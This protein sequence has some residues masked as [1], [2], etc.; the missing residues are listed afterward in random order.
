MPGITT[1]PIT[2]P[3]AT[4]PGQI[5]YFGGP[6]GLHP[7]GRLTGPWQQQPPGSGGVAVPPVVNPR[8]LEGPP[9]VLGP[10]D[11]GRYLLGFMAGYN[12]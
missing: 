12:S 10:P 9:N 4:G 11:W 7:L 8:P 2:H 3:G 5:H 6:G 1:G